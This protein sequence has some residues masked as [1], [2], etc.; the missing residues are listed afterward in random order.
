MRDHTESPRR[1]VLQK[2]VTTLDPPRSTQNQ[3][4]IDIASSERDALVK[5][6]EH[7]KAACD[8]A[9]ENLAKLKSDQEAKVHEQA[10][11]KADKADLKR[12]KEA[13]EKKVQDAQNQLNH[14][15]QKAASSHQRVQ[16][17]KASQ[18][19]NRSQGR[20][21]D[22]LNRLRDSGRIEGFHGRLGSL[23]TIPDKYDV[24]ISTACPQLNNM[25]VDKVEQGQKCL[26]YL[27]EQ[28]P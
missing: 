17:A 11:C 7:A 27:R 19:K 26:Q 5:K 1:K 20:V 8:E 25:V 6:A 4:E 24:A 23:G 15:R 9:E 14:W 10:K 2:E 13:A 21:L 28:K 16:E 12:S 18:E 22:G 3:S